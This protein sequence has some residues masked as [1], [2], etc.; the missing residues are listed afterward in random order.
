MVAVST[1]TGVVAGCVFS[2]ET[3]AFVTA[4]SLAVIGAIVALCGLYGGK[5]DDN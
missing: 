2:S 1:F 3:V 5:K 4:I